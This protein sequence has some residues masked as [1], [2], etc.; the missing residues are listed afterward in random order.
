MKYKAQ[1]TTMCQNLRHWMISL[2][3][4]LWYETTTFS[5]TN[6]SNE[7]EKKSKGMRGGDRQSEI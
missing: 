2:Q 3:R 6:R 1:G 7:T 5:I 4:Y